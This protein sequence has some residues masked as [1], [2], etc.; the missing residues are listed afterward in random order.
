MSA[1]RIFGQDV[2][3]LA[4]HNQLCQGK[5]DSCT[6][7]CSALSPVKPFKQVR[8]IFFL[9]SFPAVFNYDF[10]I[11]RIF[12]TGNGQPAIFRRVLYGVF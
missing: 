10:R 4:F 6:V 12:F 5:T 9:K 8:N 1:G 11:E 2:P 7:L 3:V